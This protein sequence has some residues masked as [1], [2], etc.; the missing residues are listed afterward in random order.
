[1]LKILSM[2]FCNLKLIIYEWLFHYLPEHV[3]PSGASANPFL[4]EHRKLPKL[5]SQMWSHPPWFVEHSFTS[6]GEIEAFG[7]WC[8]YC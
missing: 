5:F 8:E 6:K 3:A 1:M 4:Q 7:K 2:K